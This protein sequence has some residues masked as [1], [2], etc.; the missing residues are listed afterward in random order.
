M[1]HPCRHYPLLHRGIQNTKRQIKEMMFKLLGIL[2]VLICWTT[3]TEASEGSRHLRSDLRGYHVKSK[4]EHGA[5]HRRDLKAID[6]CEGC[7]GSHANSPKCAGC[8][9]DDSGDRYYGGKGGSDCK[10]EGEE[11]E[12]SYDCCPPFVCPDHPPPKD[13]HPPK[14]SKCSKQK[15]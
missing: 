12:E 8:H 14:A 15:R 4:G 5:S 11:C 7:Y 2:F 10:A 1:T 6:T 3:S 13:G 9:S